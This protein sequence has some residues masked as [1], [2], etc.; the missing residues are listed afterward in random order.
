MT[1]REIL[2]MRRASLTQN[3]AGSEEGIQIAGEARKL[4]YDPTAWDTAR[5]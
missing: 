5:P 4:G 1:P 3:I 2:A